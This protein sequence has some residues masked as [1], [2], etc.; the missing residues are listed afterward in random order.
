TN[1]QIE[2]IQNF[3][4]QAVIAIENARLLNETRE[5]LERQ[6]ATS[7]VLGVISSSQGELAPVF[8]A[9]LANATRICGAKFGTL[10][11]FEGDELRVVAMHDAPPAYEELRR[12]DP[13]VPNVVRRRYEAKQVWHSADLAADARY[14]SSHARRRALV[15]RGADAQGGR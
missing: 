11:L 3:A 1:K 15:R 10:T 14:A 2:L 9:M 4:S 6:T 7:E 12:R 13:V 5:A 8:E